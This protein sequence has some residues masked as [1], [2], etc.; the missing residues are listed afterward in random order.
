VANVAENGAICLHPRTGAPF[1]NPYLPIRDRALATLQR[2]ANV[3]Q[4][5]FL[6]Q[7]ENG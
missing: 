2:M 3:K 6:W 5:E 4:A 1:E 7:S